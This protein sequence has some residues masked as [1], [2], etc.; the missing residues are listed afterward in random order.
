M[1]MYWGEFKINK[2]KKATKRELLKQEK[3]IQLE[4]EYLEK[5]EKEM[6]ELGI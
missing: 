4:I 3:M 1:N 2:M 5:K 6:I